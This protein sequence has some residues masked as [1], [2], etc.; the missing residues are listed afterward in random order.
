MGRHTHTHTYTLFCLQPL[1]GKGLKKIDNSV[2]KRIGG[3]EEVEREREVKE[4]G[5][6]LP[7]GPN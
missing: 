2:E 3:W 6:C 5:P 4:G 1:T 7:A